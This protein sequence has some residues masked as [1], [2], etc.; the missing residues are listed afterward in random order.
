MLGPKTRIG[1]ITA[2]RFFD[3]AVI[4]FTL[5]VAIGP[6]RGFAAE[7]TSISS[8]DTLVAVDKGSTITI[9]LYGIDA[10]EAGQQGS[11]AATRFLRSLVVDHPVVV[12]TVE[13][14]GFERSIAIVRRLQKESSINAAMVAHGYAWVN[15]KSCTADECNQWKRLER[16]A[17][18]FRLG[19]W[20]G[21]DLVPPWEF[22]T[23]QRR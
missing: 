10:P 11:N 18:N 9:R 13:T 19:I 4:I 23:Q 16:Q 22:R 1:R 7:I 6:A 20:S 14:D 3:S 17:Q 2:P 15:P 8:G 21:Y 5:W 12:E